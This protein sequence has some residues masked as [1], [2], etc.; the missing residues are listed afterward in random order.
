MRAA[1]DKYIL[2]VFAGERAHKLFP[3][4]VYDGRW[5]VVFILCLEDEIVKLRQFRIVGRRAEAV[6][7]HAHGLAIG[8]SLEISDPLI[9]GDDFGI[10]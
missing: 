10:A 7:P 4:K 9:V 3:G 6:R 2:A 5:K 8:A 1:I